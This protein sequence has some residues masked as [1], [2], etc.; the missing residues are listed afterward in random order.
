MSKNLQ[1][2]RKIAQ[3]SE[4]EAKLLSSNLKPIVLLEAKNGSNI[5][6]SV[7]PN[8][9]KLGVMLAFSGI[10]LLLFDHLEHDIIATSANISGEVVIKDE[11]ELREKLGEGNKCTEKCGRNSY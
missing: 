11:S 9:N 7:A 10:H 8:L 4:A 1:N 2:A 3:I 5:A 6:K